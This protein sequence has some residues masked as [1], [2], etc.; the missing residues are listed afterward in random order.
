MATRKQSRGTEGQDAIALLIDDHE[1]VKEL[2]AEFRKFQEAK[3]E[4]AD[5]MK[6]ALMD[7]VCAALKVH[8]QI[9]EEIFYPAARQAL[10]DE[11]D[12]FNEAQVEHAA[13]KELIAQVEAG[14][15]RDDMT[16]A[17]FQV[18]SE[19]VDH[20]VKEEQDEMFPKLRKSSMDMEAVGRKLEKRRA[21]LE[22]EGVAAAVRIP[23]IWDRLSTFAR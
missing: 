9:E 22:S 17:R 7:A 11:K 19:Q 6:Q 13:A 18:L 10:P 8:T 23:T 1:A 2:F 21:E 16:C 14:S 4:G 15:A 20:H 12:L 5:E 3:T